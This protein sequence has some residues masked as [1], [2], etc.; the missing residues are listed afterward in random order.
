MPSYSPGRARKNILL[1][2]DLSC[3]PASPPQGIL[4]R[5][6]DIL[7]NTIP[8]RLE[9]ERDREVLPSPQATELQRAMAKGPEEGE[10]GCVQAVPVRDQVCGSPED[11]AGRRKAVAPGSPHFL[12]IGFH[13]LGSTVVD[14][15]P[16]VS[17]VNAHA[18]GHRGHN[19]LQNSSH[20]PLGDPKEWAWLNSHVLGEVLI[21][22][23]QP[24]LQQLQT[25][26]AEFG[27]ST[28]IGS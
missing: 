25:H 4:R 13:L 26:R 27:Q 9:Q 21:L 3:L 20:V 11:V 2:P 1:K 28:A 24:E 16:D 12:V 18:K 6:L 5:E 19:A 22:R 8:K 14:H 15:Q 10:K 17:L 23:I 7:P